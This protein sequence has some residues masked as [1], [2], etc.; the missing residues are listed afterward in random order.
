MEKKDFSDKFQKLRKKK[1]L[2]LRRVKSDKVEI[3]DE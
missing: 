1:H 3:R 2:Q